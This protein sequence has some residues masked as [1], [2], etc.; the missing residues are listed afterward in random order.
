MNITGPSLLIL[1]AGMGSRYGGLK[2]IDAV[3]PSG[4]T[5][6]DYSIHDALAAG[7]RKIVFVIRHDIEKDFKESVGSRY[8]EMVD[9]DYV[10]QELDALPDGMTVP[11]GRTKPWGTGHAILVAETAI[12]EPFGV[13][14]ADDFYGRD[15]YEQLAAFL[16]QSLPNRVHAMVGYKMRNTL[17]EHGTVSRGVCQKSREGYLQKVEEV[18]AISKTAEGACAGEKKFSGNEIVSMNLW[19]FQ[20]GIF[21]AL[22]SQFETFYQ[23]HGQEAKSEFYIPFVVDEEIAS[24]RAKVL[25]LE[26]DSKWTGVTYRE[27]KPGVEKFI[28]QLTEKGAYPRNLFQETAS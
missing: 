7:F 28:Q 21:K 4:E 14:N 17:S 16:S 1:A 25:V 20:P 2:Q 6:L 26:T 15:A 10:F 22:Q 18:T 11:D 13:I 12:K 23:Q 27:D 5:I 24:G 9:V 8:E 19:G 3:G